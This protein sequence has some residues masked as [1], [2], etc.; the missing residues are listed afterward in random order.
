M[1]NEVSNKSTDKV[2]IDLSNYQNKEKFSNLFKS[3]KTTRRSFFKRGAAVTTAIVALLGGI[4]AAMPGFAGGLVANLASETILKL[5]SGKTNLKISWSKKP[6]AIEN[7]TVFDTN[8][9]L[10]PLFS[11]DVPENSVG[12]Y[13]NRFAAQLVVQNQGENAVTF[14]EIKFTARNITPIE[15]PDLRMS[16]PSSEYE[17]SPYLDYRAAQMVI[18]NHGWGYARYIVLNV[19]CRDP[20]FKQTFGWESRDTEISDIPPGEDLLITVLGVEDISASV[21]QEISI[22]DISLLLRYS[23]DGPADKQLDIKYDDLVI[24]VSK[25]SVSFAGVGDGGKLSTI[26]GIYVDA[27]AESY[28]WSEGIATTVEGHGN[29]ILPICFFPNKS[30]SM[31]YMITLNYS[32]T[33]G[34]TTPERE[35]EFTVD[36]YYSSAEAIDASSLTAEQLLRAVKEKKQEDP[37]GGDNVAV[38]F[39]WSTRLD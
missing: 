39:P 33:E 13:S 4:E 10:Y 18:E 22:P 34:V 38:A 23:S 14:T 31:S 30:C 20:A 2:K 28:E 5:F 37:T 21:N 19:T 15:I 8:T 29:A 25:D 7:T 24:F 12:F 3:A 35:A 17:E 11:D 32:D 27:D 16:P 9:S 26:F 6:A 36:S 1:K